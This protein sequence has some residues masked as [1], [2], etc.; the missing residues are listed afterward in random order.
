MDEEDDLELTV[1]PNI[2]FLD[3][4][5][6]IENSGIFKRNL[7][8]EYLSRSSRAKQN[9]KKQDNKKKKRIHRMYYDI[10]INDLISIFEGKLDS[11]NSSIK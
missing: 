10:S 8:F 1:Y 6:S 7:Q 11:Y 3:L 4:I 5:D 9:I 2:L